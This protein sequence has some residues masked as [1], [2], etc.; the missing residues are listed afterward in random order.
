MGANMVLSRA[1]ANSATR[2]ITMLTRAH[3]F[4]QA[5]TNKLAPHPRRTISASELAL[6][7]DPFV[8]R[9]KFIDTKAEFYVGEEWIY[10]FSDG[11]MARTHG[12][13]KT[14]YIWEV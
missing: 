12:R 4:V 6:R 1:Q 13:G 3:K 8:Q 7:V 9:A 14:F 10:T 2:E 5:W 11:S